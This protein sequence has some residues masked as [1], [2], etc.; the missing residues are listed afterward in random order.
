MRVPGLSRAAAAAARSWDM[1]ITDPGSRERAAE[2]PLD[3]MPLTGVMGAE[4]HGVDLVDIDD[5]TL[6]AL[7][8]AV[9]DRGVVILRDQRLT[10]ETQTAFTRRL[11]PDAPVHFVEAMPG[12]PGV[13]RVLK[14]A[15]DGGAFNFGGAW[16]SDFSFEPAPPS[17]TILHAVDV[18]PYGGDT[19]W[20]SMYAAWESCA[21]AVQERLRGVTARHTARDAYS[22]KMQAIHSGLSSMRI[23]CDESANDVHAHP[24]VTVHPETGREVLFFNSAY[25]RDLRGVPSDEVP[26]LLEW[27]HHHT[28]NIRFTARHRWRAGDVAIWDNRCTQ[29][30][31]LNDYAGAR[32]ELH[33]TTV[34][35][36]VPMAAPAA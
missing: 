9:C 30:L 22:P 34:A 32:R 23:V 24:L 2:R 1:A 35:G 19:V 15:A 13:I 7:R 8:A 6:A 14:E 3:L 33:R 12:H 36:E 17:F 20:S 21:R 26:A 5:A 10:P 4:A 11:G 29:H 28:T 18:P 16:H 27:L 31:A 25:V